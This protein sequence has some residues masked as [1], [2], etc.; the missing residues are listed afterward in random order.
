M[1][2]SGTTEIPLN[3][4]KINK[5]VGFLLLLTV[6]AA[7]VVARPEMI[8]RNPF[9]HTPTEVRLFGI[10]CGAFVGAIGFF[11]ARK[12]ADKRPGLLVTPDG[13]IDYSSGLAVGVVLWADIVAWQEVRFMGQQL[14]VAKLRDPDKYINQHTN[15][16]R[17]EQLRNYLKSHGSPIF[18]SAGLLQCSH[19]E[20]AALLAAHWAA[21]RASA[22]PAAVSRSLSSWPVGPYFE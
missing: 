9:L 10:V 6:G 3:K 17:K 12:L 18:A 11:L 1:L 14:T 8:P 2:D 21:Y 19:A 22:V 13:F 20:L 16:F 4:Q 5:L 7:S 15:P